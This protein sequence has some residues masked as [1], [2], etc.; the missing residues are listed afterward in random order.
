[1]AKAA[2]KAAAKKK[3]RSKVGATEVAPPASDQ[4]NMSIRK[5]SNG[6][7]V[8]QSGYKAGKYV[9]RETYTPRKPQITIPGK[10]STP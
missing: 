5:I 6:Y 7:L 10:G 3:G 4:V 8:S 2:K 1:M 9:S